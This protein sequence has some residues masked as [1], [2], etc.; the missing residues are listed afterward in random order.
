VGTQAY[1][2]SSRSPGEENTKISSGTQRKPDSSALD[3]DAIV[4]CQVFLAKDTAI[5]LSQDATVAKDGQVKK[6]SKT[7][8]RE[9]FLSLVPSFQNGESVKTVDH[10]SVLGFVEGNDAIT[11]LYTTST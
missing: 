6:L 4:I 8:H 2:V 1:P 7:Q 11:I 3:D 10:A 5:L 9:A